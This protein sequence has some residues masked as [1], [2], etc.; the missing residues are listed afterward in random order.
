MVS[1][2]IRGS[3]L[4]PSRFSEVGSV[5]ELR[6]QDSRVL[7]SAN[8]IGGPLLI[9]RGPGSETLPASHLCRTPLN[10]AHHS[11]PHPTFCGFLL[12]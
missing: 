9:T 10:A 1:E 7:N 6:N 5:R 2:P 11:T 3:I 12:T 8:P 4:N